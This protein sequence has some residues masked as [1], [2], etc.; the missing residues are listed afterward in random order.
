MMTFLRSL[1]KPLVKS[2]FMLKKNK[3][4]IKERIIDTSK[5]FEISE[6]NTNKFLTAIMELIERAKS[7]VLFC[8]KCDER[9]SIDLET[10]V[11]QCFN[12]GAKIKISAIITTDE[13]PLQKVPSSVV[14]A[15]K[16]VTPTVVKK[17]NSAIL[18]AVDALESTDKK[19]SSILDVA[20]SRGGAKVT[21]ED[22]EY[23][24]KNVPGGGSKIN[25]S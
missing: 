5:D 19:K 3:K 17:P 10:G 22:E 12:C 13:T 25:W 18:K 16:V 15:E 7:P 8:S 23:V 24:K 4:T 21:K 9:M 6:D 11:L 1:I 20:N 14:N 2:K